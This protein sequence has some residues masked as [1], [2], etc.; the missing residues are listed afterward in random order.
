MALE[1]EVIRRKLEQV[2]ILANNFRAT[3]DR[4]HR[5]KA[6]KTLVAYVESIQS[7]L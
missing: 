4:A 6:I 3:T 5:E 1:P 7:E 2:K